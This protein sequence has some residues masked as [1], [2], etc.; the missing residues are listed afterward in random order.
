MFR[1]ADTGVG[2]VYLCVLFIGMS[3]GRGRICF[4]PSKKSEK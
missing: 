4:A 1:R 2:G 3:R